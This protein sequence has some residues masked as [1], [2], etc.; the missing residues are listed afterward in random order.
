MHACAP[1]VWQ[2]IAAA[3]VTGEEEGDEVGYCRCGLR[4]EKMRSLHTCGP[5]SSAW[6]LPE[7]PTGT[8]S[9]V[10]ATRGRAASRME[11]PRGKW[12]EMGWHATG[13]IFLNAFIG[14]AVP[15]S[16]YY[17]GLRDTAPAYAVIF[18]NIIPLV[19]FIL[20]L[21]FRMET[22]QILSI[23]GSLKVVGVVLS[24]GGTMLISLYKGKTLHLWKPVLRHMGQN[25]T[26]VA[27]NHLRGTIFL[28]GSSITLACWYLIQS[29]VMKV[30][31]YKYW[32]SIV[33]CLVGGFQTALVGIILSR[34]KSA[35]KLGWDL[36]L[37]TI[38][39]S[40]AL[41]TAGKYSLNSW[42][43]AKRGP[44]YPPMF[45]PLSVVFTV[46]LD[47][48]FIGDEI[49]T[50]SLFGTTVVIAGLYIF[51]SAKSKEVRD[52]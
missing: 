4:R 41:A 40:G 25:T 34:D 33:T 30:Y 51:L 12:R 13:W 21:V 43:V 8:G 27:G 1:S 28:V 2:A 38:F 48:I 17:Y 3:R 31:P 15:M 16:L 22:L 7:R 9:A 39:Y 11:A 20:S 23:A 46:L 50:G 42:V 35:W 32:S 19:T 36:N 5:S 26:E 44:A 49:T 18:L 14:Y 52:K 45:S 29:K 47:S 24:V 37:L 6:A 10:A